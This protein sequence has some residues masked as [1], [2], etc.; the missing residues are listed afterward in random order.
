MII[1]FNKGCESPLEFPL[2]SIPVNAGSSGLVSPKIGF[3]HGIECPI[4]GSNIEEYFWEVQEVRNLVNNDEFPHD[5]MRKYYPPSWG[6]YR[7]VMPQPLVAER[8][9]LSRPRGCANVVHMDSPVDVGLAG[10]GWILGKAD[11]KI[12]ST[13]HVD[14]LD[15]VPNV[16]R[17]MASGVRTSLHQ[18]FEVKYFFG[19]ARP[20]EV[21]EA[22]GHKD[23]EDLTAYPEG[24]PAHCSFP[25]G[26][27]AAA[28]GGLKAVIDSF[29]VS[30]DQLQELRDTAY[31]W[32]QF[33]SLAGVHYG[34]DNIAGLAVSGLLE[35]DEF[36]SFYWE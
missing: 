22:L 8:L 4:D 7:E 2:T 31:F 28:G 32:A 26:H 21:Y 9:N 1:Q 18:A 17:N 14:F 27:G 34:P 35:K 30:P 20:E 24:C 16:V 33:R 19:L 23:P 12:H 25:A 15:A 10:L 3:Q 6:E 5:F 13:G 29:H 11:Q 36:N